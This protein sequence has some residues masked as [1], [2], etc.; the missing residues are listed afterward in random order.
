[1]SLLSGEIAQIVWAETKSLGSGDADGSGDVNQVRRLVAQLA[2]SVDGVGFSKREA[3]PSLT[4]PKYGDTVRALTSIA[5][6]AVGSTPPQ[7][8]MIFWVAGDDTQRPVSMTNL[9]P[10]P[11]WKTMP[12]EG[13]IYIGRFKLTNRRELDVFSRTPVEGDANHP[14]F[15][16]AVT[17]TGNPGGKVPLLQV[18]PTLAAPK[19]GFRLFVAACIAFVAA[20]VW[21]YGVGM[22]SRQTVL[23]F[24]AV[25]EAG[26]CSAEPTNTDFVFGPPEWRYAGGK[27]SNCQTLYGKMQAKVAQRDTMEQ[28]SLD[29]F[30]SWA[31]TA[32]GDMGW[33]VSLFWP[34]VLGLAALTLLF[35]SAGY[36]INGRPLGVIIDGRYRMSLTMAQLALWSIVILGGWL[37]VGLYN[38][39]FGGLTYGALDQAAVANPAMT[40]FK[41]M[42]KAYNLIPTIP[43]ELMAVLGLSAASPFISRLIT[44][45]S[46]VGSPE[47]AQATKKTESG[48]VVGGALKVNAE[49]SQAALAD[50]VVNETEGNNNLVDPTRVQ[51]AAMTGI[52]VVSYATLL[53]DAVSSI[54]PTRTVLAAS[55]PIAVITNLPSIDATFIA[56][57]FVSH[58]AL[59]GSKIYDKKTGAGSPSG[60]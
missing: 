43:R 52:L 55:R 37:V 51:Y 2:A 1:M 19:T 24:D 60:G 11:P 4:D 29:R 22:A 10:P 50:M 33:S 25:K 26:K 6:A 34:L 27:P 3:L 41:D 56:L 46:L 58:A 12:E 39:G 21:A 59:W 28:T 18:P 15:V 57:L 14:V 45:T 23:M 17:G 54:E 13:I 32:S 49:P 9:P 30:A 5:D 53:F 42:V 48:A 47:D 35:V 36:G 44:N 40:T 7:R 20:A 8:R 31:L 38:F 16:N